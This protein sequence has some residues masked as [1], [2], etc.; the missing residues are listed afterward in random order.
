VIGA[1][2]PCTLLNSR[3]AETLS[4]VRVF[5]LGGPQ[6]YGPNTVCEYRTTASSIQGIV[7]INLETTSLQTKSYPDTPADWDHLV[8][9]R[10]EGGPITV[11]PS[12]SS[13]GHYGWSYGPVAV[14]PI[15]DHGY[16][17]ACGFAKRGYGYDLSARWVGGLRPTTRTTLVA[18]C[19][20][21]DLQ[22]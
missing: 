18:A 19:N 3:T 13:P 1:P 14:G 16:I 5:S 4:G 21:L 9:A 15:S 8:H 11:I 7:D 12:L 2:N 6:H 10:S 22:A 20:K 17:G